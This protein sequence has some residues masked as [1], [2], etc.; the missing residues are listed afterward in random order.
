MGIIEFVGFYL[1]IGLLLAI[2]TIVFITIKDSDVINIDA[3]IDDLF[4]IGI[5]ITLLWPVIP[6][7]FFMISIMYIF[8]YSV[9]ILVNITLW[10]KRKFLRGNW[11][12]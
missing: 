5:G 8:Y 1:L 7:A 3:A 6:V 11:I 4:G 10:T 12:L 9:R 2:L